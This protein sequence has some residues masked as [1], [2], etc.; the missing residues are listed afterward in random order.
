MTYVKLRCFCICHGL[1]GD[2]GELRH[3]GRTASARV[4]EQEEM[5]SPTG[6]SV[7]DHI[8]CVTACE[9]CRK[10]HAA[11]LTPPPSDLKWI[12][13]PIQPPPATGCSDDEGSE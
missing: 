7:H 9:G 11:V 13:P 5:A 6:V 10:F 3:W 8:A 4:L 2:A 1:L 12:D